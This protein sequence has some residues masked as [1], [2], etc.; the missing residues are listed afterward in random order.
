ME[1]H[2][3]SRRRC[4]GTP[5]RLEQGLWH[6]RSWAQA[7]NSKEPS[8]LQGPLEGLERGQPQVPLQQWA[9]PCLTCHLLPTE[10]QE[11]AHYP[12]PQRKRSRRRVATPILAQ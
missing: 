2:M 10:N 11:G 8:Y 7:W 12:S 3:L 6:H 5:S 4:Q 1:G 9:P